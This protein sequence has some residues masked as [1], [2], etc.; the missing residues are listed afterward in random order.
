MV[1]DSSFLV[2]YFLEMDA[3]NA[4]AIGLA[5]RHEKES[6]L[7]PDLVL[8]ETL[9]LICYRKGAQ[10][11]R[12]AYEKISGNSQILLHDFSAEEKREILDRFLSQKGKLGFVDVA[13]LHLAEKTGSGIIS[14]DRQLLKNK[15]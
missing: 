8:Y 1:L 7:L 15:K 10:G 12:E 5:E 2:A 3:N 9:T 4:K 11:A 13:I 6:L 14:F